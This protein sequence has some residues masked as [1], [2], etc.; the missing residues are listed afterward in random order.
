MNLRKSKSS[1][2]IFDMGNISSVYISLIYASKDSYLKFG[3]AGQCYNITP[4]S[5]RPLGRRDT[6][7]TF[8]ENCA[9]RETA[10][11]PKD[12]DQLFNLAIE[13]ENYN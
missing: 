10:A 5:A 4:T 3:Y 11:C 8:R 2:E 6:Q 1:E 13:R 7:D 9:D 12:V